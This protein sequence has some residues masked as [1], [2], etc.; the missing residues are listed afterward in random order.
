MKI[1]SGQSCTLQLVS[2]DQQHYFETKKT[3]SCHFGYERNQNLPVIQGPHLFHYS[4]HV[5]IKAPSA[6]N[7]TILGSGRATAGSCLWSLASIPLLEDFPMKHNMFFMDLKQHFKSK[8]K[9][10]LI[11]FCKW[12]GKW[13]H[14]SVVESYRG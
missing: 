12:H 2:G 7:V 1:W 4:K 13:L 10:F 3:F 9:W 5:S 14:L 11:D 8:T 6:G